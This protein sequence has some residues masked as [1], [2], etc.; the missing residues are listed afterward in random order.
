MMKLDPPMIAIPLLDLKMRICSMHS[1]GSEGQEEEE[2]LWEEWEAFSQFL[3]TCLAFKEK[4]DLD[5]KTKPQKLL[6][7]QNYNF[8]KQ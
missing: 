3:R 5:A 7:E 2:D 1:E 6:L 8:Q 4:E